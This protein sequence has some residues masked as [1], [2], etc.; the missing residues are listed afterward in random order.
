[1]VIIHIGEMF[2]SAGDA[3]DAGFWSR[4]RS[5]CCVMDRDI[6]CVQA[7]GEYLRGSENRM[8]CS[9][10]LSHMTVT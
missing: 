1:M 8:K 7:Y 10:L 3:R 4:A 9:H 6:D 2:G 5:D